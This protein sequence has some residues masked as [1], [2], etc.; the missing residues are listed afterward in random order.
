MTKKDFI[1]IADAISISVVN[2]RCRNELLANLCKMLKNVNPK[3][4]ERT[5]REYIIQKTR[6]A[7]LERRKAD[8][9][10]TNKLI[11]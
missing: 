2:D 1:L 9:P 10:L 5:F 3:F 11:D 8:V 6:E 7:K 4:D